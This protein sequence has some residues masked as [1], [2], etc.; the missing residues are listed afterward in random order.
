M[1]LDF[2]AGMSAEQDQLQRAA[3][4]I[5][6][7]MRRRTG[8]AKDVPAGTSVPS[9]CKYIYVRNNVPQGFGA[10]LLAATELE[11]QH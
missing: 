7:R 1:A 5:R 2:G 6:H 11:F 9:E 10:V 4:G 8:I 3:E